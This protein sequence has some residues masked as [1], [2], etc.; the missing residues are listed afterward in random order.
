TFL[1]KNTLLVG[2]DRG[3]SLHS[4][5]NALDSTWSF[6][7]TQPFSK[8]LS[9]SERLIAQGRDPEAIDDVNKCA[10]AFNSCAADQNDGDNEVTGLIVSNGVSTAASVYGT[11]DPGKESDALGFYTGQHGANVT[12]QLIPPGPDSGNTTPGSVGPPGPPGSAG[13]P[14]QNGQDG[15]N[16]APGQNGTNGANGANGA[17]GAQGNQGPQGTQGPQ[18]E[19]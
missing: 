4:A 6:D 7:L 18:G 19:R 14:G 1:D 17:T 5:Y 10:P 16:G 11:N 8:Q 3:D 9:S 13:P 2:E 12:Y 15:T